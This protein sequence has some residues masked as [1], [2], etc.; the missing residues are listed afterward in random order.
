M[1]FY[2]LGLLTLLISLFILNS[3]KNQDGIG[4]GVDENSQLNGTI[5]TDT[6]MV[7]TTVREDT[8]ITSGQTRTPLSYF[9]DPILGITES[10][11]A[12]LLTLPND[13]AYTLPTGTIT[14]DS[15]RLVMPYAPAGFYGDSLASTYKVNVHQLNEKVLNTLNYYN[16]KVWD[17]KPEVLGT[18]T[19]IARPHDSIRIFNILAGRSDTLRKV[20]PQIRI[21]IDPDFINTYVLQ[22][23][24]IYRSST[25]AF[26]NAVKGL[27]ITLDKTGTTGV[28]GNLM[29]NMDSVK[30]NVYYKRT[31][32]TTVDTS[33]IPLKIV[34]AVH[35]AQIKHTYSTQVQAA[36]NGTAT[37]GQ[38]YLQ[39]MAG[40]RA[41]VTFPNIK[42]TFAALGTNVVINRAEI[43][44]TANPN[45]IIPYA[46]LTR[47]TM[48]QF[49]LAKQR[50]RLQDASTSDPRGQNGLAFFGGFYQTNSEYHFLVTSY[51]QDLFRGKTVD[52]GTFIAPVDPTPLNT[53]ITIT[54]TAQYAERTIFAGKNAPYRIKL[55]IIYTKINQ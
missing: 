50:V 1:K 22:A 11:I 23:P 27:F 37:D 41:K 20:V 17:Y 54:P 39:P 53:G 19:F 31:S 10:N 35:A 48:Y 24:A 6:S 51:I 16:N 47:L 44:V 30:L 52:Y 43:V 32:G 3:C 46:P 28:G 12:A 7:V 5:I 13:A 38:V 29:F 18:K 15:I 26:Q 49:D 21:P 2:K 36:L 8:V 9:K 42:N 14:V 4:L 25:L 45:T 40:L 34:P 33:V 55:N